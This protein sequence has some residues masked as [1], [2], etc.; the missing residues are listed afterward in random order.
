MILDLLSRKRLPSLPLSLLSRKA[1]NWKSTLVQ[2]VKRFLAFEITEE[3]NRTFV[4]LNT[5]L[6]LHREWN[7]LMSPSRLCVHQKWKKIFGNCLNW[8]SRER[9]TQLVGNEHHLNLCSESMT[10]F[11]QKINKTVSLTTFSRLKRFGKRFRSSAAHS[12]LLRVRLLSV[13]MAMFDA[14]MAEAVDSFQYILQ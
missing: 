13:S 7:Q 10:Q 2:S 4:Y 9:E 14:A 8:I 12:L 1:W 5:T 6:C 11:I 3:R